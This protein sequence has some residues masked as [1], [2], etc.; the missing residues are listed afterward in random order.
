MHGFQGVDKNNNI[1]TFGRG[2]SDTS[3]VAI[4]AAFNA[5]GVIFIQMLM[6]FIPATLEWLQKLRN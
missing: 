2:G 5:I 4:A 6:E 3:A 1:V